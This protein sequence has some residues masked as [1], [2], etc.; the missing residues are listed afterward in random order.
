MNR[1]GPAGAG[2]PCPTRAGVTSPFLLHPPRVPGFPRLFRA[3]WRCAGWFSSFVSRASAFGPPRAVIRGNKRQTPEIRQSLNHCQQGR[4]VGPSARAPVSVG[5]LTPTAPW[6]AH[7]PPK[8]LSEEAQEAKPAFLF[9]AGLPLRSSW[10][11][12]PSP[13]YGLPED[14]APSTVGHRIWDRT[15]A[16]PC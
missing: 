11:L 8:Q 7:G 3:H 14:V 10:Q 5:L 1:G 12:L 2:A 13:A 16:P 4:P 9:G 15:G 6:G